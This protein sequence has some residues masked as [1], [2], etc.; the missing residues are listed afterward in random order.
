VLF[1]GAGEM[2]ELCATHFAAKPQR[3]SCH[4]QPHAG[5]WRKAGQ[6]LRRRGDAPE[7]TCPTACTSS[8][9]WSAAPPAPCPSSA[10]A[11]W[12]G[13][14]SASPPPDVHG[15]PGRAA[16]HRAR[17]QGPGGHLPLHRGRPGHVVQTGQ[18]NRQAAVAQAEAIIDAGVQSFMHWM[19]QRGTVPLIQ[20]LNAQADEWRSARDRTRPQAAGQGRERR[21]RAGSPVA[22]PDAKDAARRDG[23]TARRRRRGARA[24]STA[25][26]HFF[27]RKER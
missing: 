23:R 19:D 11:R 22:R 12:S 8:T 24:A 16:R 25:I 17:S 3:P 9:P 26:Q 18:A 2:I 13:R 14:S 6:P 21:R 7:P 1:V 4:C 5:A 20:Q 10:W 27:L 15:R